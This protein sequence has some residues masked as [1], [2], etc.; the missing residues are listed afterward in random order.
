[1]ALPVSLPYTVSS[2]PEAKLPL[3]GGDCT[4][5]PILLA[6]GAGSLSFPLGMKNSSLSAAKQVGSWLEQ[7]H[8]CGQQQARSLVGT[9]R[10]A[11]L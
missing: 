9:P 10:T 1:M 6:G 2:L 11:R 4:Q 8:R 5:Q 3:L 7:L